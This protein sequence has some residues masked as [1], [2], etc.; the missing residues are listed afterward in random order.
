[1][2]KKGKDFAKDFA[3]WFKNEVL[4]KLSD[5]QVEELK[6]RPEIVAE[7]F[8]K[9]FKSVCEERGLDYTKS[10]MYQE[11]LKF[12]AEHPEKSGPVR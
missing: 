1:M 12:R 7:T 6:E 11:E 3:E 5:E 9:A 10:L 8:F 4:P 2:E